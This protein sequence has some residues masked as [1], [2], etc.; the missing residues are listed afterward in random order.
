MSPNDVNIAASIATSDHLTSTMNDAS[1]MNPL[2]WINTQTVF[3]LAPI[4]A[5]AILGGAATAVYDTVSLIDPAGTAVVTFNDDLSGLLTLPT[6][7]MAFTWA[8]NTAVNG[9][10]QPGKDFSGRN[11]PATLVV[12]F[13]DGTKVNLYGQDNG[14]GVFTIGQFEVDNLGT[15]SNVDG[16]TATRR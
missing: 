1:L 2:A 8:E 10:K 3:N 12:T 4:S 11:Y 5:A 7:D 6:G 13:V 9:A 15:L 14:A 16:F